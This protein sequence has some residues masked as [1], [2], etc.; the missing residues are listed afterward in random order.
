MNLEQVGRTIRQ[1]RQERGLTLETLAGQANVSASMLHAVEHGRKAPTIVVLDRIAGGLGVR[2]PALL[3]GLEDERLV[4][5]HA[6]AQVVVDEPG[7]W[8]RRILSPLIPGV[9][10]EWVRV[11]LPPGCAPAAYPAYAPGSHEFIHVLEG[12]VRVTIGGRTVHLG[13]GDTLYFAADSAHAYANDGASP[14]VYEVVALVMRPRR[15]RT[16]VP[17]CLPAAP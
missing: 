17:D 11:T 4:V 3:G 15:P 10:V 16:A 12:A 6:D 7:G 14:C 8:Q 1:L 5:T 9:N 13:D 2:L